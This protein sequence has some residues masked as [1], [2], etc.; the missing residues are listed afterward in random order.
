MLPGY[1]K[2]T[3][4]HALKQVDRGVDIP[5]PD[6]GVGFAEVLTPQPVYYNV[7]EQ[8][9]PV[10]DRVKTIEQ[11]TY[12]GYGQAVSLDQFPM[13]GYIGEALGEV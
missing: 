13:T 9:A 3:N 7:G 10:V 11:A 4:A 8:R 5:D 6:L 2:L 12:D 1:H